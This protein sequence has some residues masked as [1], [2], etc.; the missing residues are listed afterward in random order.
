MDPKK[1]HNAHKR[2]VGHV[3]NNRLHDAFRIQNKFLGL[4]NDQYLQVQTEKHRDNY[5]NILQYSF[6]GGK[7]PGR[8]KIIKNLKRSLLELGEKTKESVMAQISGLHTYQV[9]WNIDNN[10]KTEYENAFAKMENLAL[11]DDL[12]DILKETNISTS[13]QEKSGIERLTLDRIFEYLWLKDN[14][15]DEDV[16]L[17]TLIKD[18]QQIAQVHKCMVVSALTLSILRYFNIDKLILLKGFYQHN[19]SQV[20]Q[21]ALIGLVFA[22]Y[23]YDGRLFLYPE[24]NKEIEQLKK[25]TPISF[26]LKDVYLQLLKARE[27]ETISQKW[28]E[29][30]MPEV[31]K[32]RPKLEDK[33]DLDNIISDKFTEDENPDWS[34]FFEDSPDLLDKLAQF[35]QMQMEG[36]DVFMGTFAKLKNYPFFQNISNWFVPFYKEHEAIEEVVNNET[37]KVDI[38]PLIENLEKTFFMCNSDKYS[39]CLNLK[40]MPDAQKS[41]MTELYKQELNSI[42]E[43]GK[44]DEMLEPA[45]KDKNIFAQ[46]IQDLYRFFKL[47]PYKNEI[48]DVF[49]TRLDLYNC[50]FFWQIASDKDFIRKIA[51]FNF[52]KKHFGEAIEL[53]MILYNQEPENTEIIEKTAYAY[54]KQKNYIEA[55]KYYLKADLLQTN[56]LWVMKKI[57][58]CYR[59]TGDYE[60]ALEYYLEAEK[61]KP[62][63]VYI[64]A[65]IGHTYL[66]LKD[67]DN[68]LK[69]Y[70]KVEYLSPEN[71]KIQ[72]PIAWCSFVLGKFDSAN[73]YL[74]KLLDKEQNKYDLM[75]KGHVEWCTGNIQN[76]ME[77]YK[78]C[79]VANE[80]DIESFSSAYDSDKNYLKKHGIEPLDMDLMLDALKEM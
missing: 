79:I 2:F 32:M 13:S 80:N 44:E 55:L 15:S 8:E 62:E 54:Q 78:K 74:D 34:S 30:I 73:R 26:H 18:S 6:R 10:L 23:K 12:S 20:W 41:M 69:Y 48:S 36:S 4:I 63:D 3:F 64:L 76:A 66:Q 67:Y 38:N 24:M 53:F 40:H 21:R 25:E 56:K 27:T 72:R 61:T 50:S 57:A 75:N 49:N 70:F 68:A 17:L 7:D 28:E 47:H 9:K 39:F 43:V 22:L 77:S 35:S 58:L 71:E 16:R 42:K 59:K 1:I 52:Q 14:Y 33:L 11:T 37:S 46:Y 19:E 51:E 60:K 65:N 29:E 31:M 45:K 5:K